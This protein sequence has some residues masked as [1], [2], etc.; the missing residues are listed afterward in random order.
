MSDADYLNVKHP[1]KSLTSESRST[2]CTMINQF[3]FFIPESSL[4]KFFS[5]GAKYTSDSK[6]AH[7]T[8]EL[9]W[10][11]RVS[12]F[13]AQ[14]KCGNLISVIWT[15]TT[16]ILRRI[17]NNDKIKV[18][19]KE[20]V[21]KSSKLVKDID[22]K[23]SI[24]YRARV[25]DEQYQ[26]SN[27][28][29]RIF[30]I[31]SAKGKEAFDDVRRQDP[32][33]FLSVMEANINNAWYYVLEY[34]SLALEMVS[35]LSVA[36][37]ADEQEWQSMSYQQVNILEKARETALEMVAKFSAGDKAREEEWKCMSYQKVNILG[38]E[39]ASRGRISQFVSTERWLISFD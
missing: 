31:M 34:T 2:W 18:S 3:F 24:R 28:T 20:G 13:V 5:S 6:K 4:N 23:Y 15:L 19:I 14:E 25:L 22:E 12:P 27:E 1:N 33:G 38:K 17:S 26:I 7:I 35:K 36:D 10:S 39:G 8:K 9:A 29:T 37:Q 21:V 32:T 16:S 30:G 11:F